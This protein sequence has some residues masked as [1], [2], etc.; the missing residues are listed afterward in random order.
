VYDTLNQKEKETWDKLIAIS[1]NTKPGSDDPFQKTLFEVRNMGASHYWDLGLLSA[2]FGFFST[3]EVT[4]H[5][6][7]YYSVGPR[8]NQVRFMFADA[9]MQQANE[10]VFESRIGRG[11]FLN[12]AIEFMA[13]FAVIVKKL[14]RNYVKNLP[15]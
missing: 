1:G 11:E 7:A 13:E 8:W 3:K 15:Y 6:R 10:S 9:A 12:E 14:I 2:F 5:S 4:G